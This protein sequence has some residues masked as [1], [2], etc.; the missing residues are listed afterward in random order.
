M[1]TFMSN[2]QYQVHQ[3][4]LH[5]DLILCNQAMEDMARTSFGDVHITFIISRD[6]LT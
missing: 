2:V 4:V 1:A 3:H 5:N 6:N